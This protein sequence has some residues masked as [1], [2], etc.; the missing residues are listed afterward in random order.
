MGSD[1][2]RYADLQDAMQTLPEQLRGLPPNMLYPM[3]LDQLVDREVIVLQA[4][5][6]KLG[7]DP[8]VQ[9]LV[10]RATDQVLQNAL[11]TR[12][13]QPMLSP[14]AIQARYAQEYAGKPGEEQ[15]RAAHIL[16]DSESKAKELIAELE[17]RPEAFAELAKAN[18]SDPSAAQNSG[19]LGW[20][21][22]ADMLPEFSDAAFALQPGAITKEPVHTRFGWHVIKAEEKR[23]APPPSVDEVRDD[24]R[25]QIIQEGV[26]R[27]LAS[28]REGVP[29]EKFNLDGSP[30]PAAA[31]APAP[32]K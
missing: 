24:L 23:T 8:K 12:D 27:V 31:P 2:I 29:V 25:R 28:A 3:L 22:K 21:K 15:V 5:K 17:K 7:D 10:R 26:A 6:E 13:I 20:F 19:E 11:L 1:T 16:V 18:S 32:T 9:A 14:E 4:R 30:M